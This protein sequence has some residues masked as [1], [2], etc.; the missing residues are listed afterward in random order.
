MDL[1]YKLNDNTYQGIFT[2]A[3]P[4]LKALR[5]FEKNGYPEMRMNMVQ[6]VL[7]SHK[8]LRGLEHFSH[9]LSPNLCILLVVQRRINIGTLM[10]R[11]SRAETCENLL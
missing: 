7:V 1:G 9:I 3:L 10:C 6:T 8:H 2:T 5:D 11:L 4:K